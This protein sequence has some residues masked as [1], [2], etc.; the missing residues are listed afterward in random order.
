MNDIQD[1]EASSVADRSREHVEL[2]LPVRKIAFWIEST[3]VRTY[4][5]SF[6][7]RVRQGRTQRGFE[8][9]S[10]NPAGG[11]RGAVSPPVGSGAEPRKILKLALF[12]G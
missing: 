8:G 11:L 7:L 12:R 6:P 2:V 9:S 4:L 3:L 1:R 10:P 5:F